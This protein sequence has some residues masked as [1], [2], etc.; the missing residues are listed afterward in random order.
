[1]A[2][3]ILKQAW[4]KLVFMIQYFCERRAEEGAGRFTDEP[5]DSVPG[6]LRRLAVHVR[7]EKPTDRRAC[8]A[9]HCNVS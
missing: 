7:N 3:K 2:I 1:M 8:V 6:T 5:L 9:M 4:E